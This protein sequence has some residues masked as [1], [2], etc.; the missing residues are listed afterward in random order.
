M[1]GFAEVHNHASVGLGAVSPALALVRPRVPFKQVIGAD[2]LNLAHNQV[3]LLDL[4]VAGRE[5]A[6]WASA[7][8]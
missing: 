3:G 6:C 4:H 7:V 1:V 5:E 8:G 2:V